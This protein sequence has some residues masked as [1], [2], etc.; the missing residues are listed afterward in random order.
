MAIT[1]LETLETFPYLDITSNVLVEVL[2]I[3]KSWTL[4]RYL[5]IQAKAKTRAETKDKVRYPGSIGQS[6]SG[7]ISEFAIRVYFNVQFLP[8]Q[9]T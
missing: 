3:S 8:R 4:S 2:D 7:M 1:T 5:I 9:V 6:N